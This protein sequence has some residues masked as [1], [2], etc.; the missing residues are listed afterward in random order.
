[1]PSHTKEQT[2][3]MTGAVYTPA[4][5][6]IS[7]IQLL[8]RRGL[9][10]G[11]KILEPSVGDGVFLDAMKAA[12][13][14]GAVTAVDI[15]KSV[16]GKLKEKW[17]GSVAHSFIQSDFLVF[18]KQCRSV[19][20]KFDLVIGN[21]PFIRRR[22]FSPQHLRSVEHLSKSE[23]Y[24]LSDIKNSWAAF[25][26]ASLAVIEDA[27][28]L[29]FVLPY[30]VLTVSYGNK[31]LGALSRIFQRI[32]IYVSR[33]R[34]FLQIDQDAIV[35]VAMKDAGELVHGVFIQM[36]DS[37]SDLE[38][39]VEASITLD[40]VDLPLALNAHLIN[41]QDR[42]LLCRACNQVGDVGS[43]CTS[44]PGVVT[45]ANDYFIL[46]EAE[47]KGR[48]LFGQTIPVLKKSSPQMIMPTL[49]KSSFEELS[50]GG[51]SRLVTLNAKDLR[52]SRVRDYVAS[53]QASNIDKRYKCAN[54]NPWYSV[55]LVRLA[56]C[57]IFKRSHSHPRIYINEAAVLT[58]DTAYGVYPK[59]GVS[60]RA[61]CFSFM[62]SLTMLYSEIGGRFYGG[63]V[64]ELSPVEFRSLPLPYKDPTEREFADFLSRYESTGGCI[65]SVLDFGDE[66]AA[67]ALGLSDSEMSRVRSAWRKVRAHRMRH[68]MRGS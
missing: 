21:P 18:A 33:E 66:W 61:M 29:V 31:L 44:A 15:D 64:L 55:P 62:N 36:V 17:A 6:A 51:K 63:G 22:N 25:V 9:L 41:E 38:S 32:D 3:S 54:R 42:D 65:E 27:G 67:R 46:T 16:I 34:A 14:H 7:L 26:L 20:A 8:R 23:N 68:G 30:E 10:A 5:I 56:P 53:G 48:G 43:Y 13:V 47:A 11:S 39:S 52:S 2:V 49:T 1:M 57:F 35:L 58:T 4:V 60:A 24:L 37:L 28:A 19:G 45:A 40:A 59:D 12:G 50:R